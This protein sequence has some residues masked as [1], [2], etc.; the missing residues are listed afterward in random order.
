MKRITEQDIDE[1]ERRV[2]NFALGED[3]LASELSLIV[4]TP[5]KQEHKLLRMASGA[6]NGARNGK[7]QEQKHVRPQRMPSPVHA[8]PRLTV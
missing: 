2:R 6:P 8:K 3:S 5:S 7:R 1:V 4:D